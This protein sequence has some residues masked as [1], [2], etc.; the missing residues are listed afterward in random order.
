MK[1]RKIIAI[2]LSAALA[3]SVTGCSFGNDALK[4]TRKAIEKIGYVDQEAEDFFDSLEDI[5]EDDWEDG[6]F[7]ETSDEDLIKEFIDYGQSTFGIKKKNVNKVLF[8]QEYGYDPGNDFPASTFRV[9][10]IEFKDKDSAEDYFDRIVDNYED[11]D[12]MFAGYSDEA[13]KFETDQDDDY[14]YMAMELESGFINSSCYVMAIKDGNIVTMMF[15]S[16]DGDHNEEFTEMMEDFC[17]ELGY[18]N[19]KDLL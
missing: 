5:E 13:L 4:T 16:T 18:D 10:C 19:P 15:V 12:D 7:S 11:L 3:L 8:A 1:N 2:V 6:L 17:D 14:F 9:N